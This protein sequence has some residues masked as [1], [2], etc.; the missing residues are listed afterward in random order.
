MVDAVSFLGRFIGGIFS[1]F[2]P[3]ESLKFAYTV[4]SIINSSILAI[5]FILMYE[6]E[7]SLV[8]PILLISMLISGVMRSLSMVPIILL[9]NN[10]N[11]QEDKISLSVW[12]ALFLLGDVV[13]LLLVNWL[14]DLGIQENYA[15]LIFVG[16]NLLVSLLQY[17][18]VDERHTLQNQNGLEYI[19]QTFRNCKAFFSLPRN[20]LWF[21]ETCSLMISYSNIIMWAPYYFS[22]IGFESQTTLISIMYPLLNC[23]SAIIF[24]FGFDQCL[25]RVPIIIIFCFMMNIVLWILL[26]F[27]GHD[28]GELVFQIFCFG[29]IG[30]FFA[31][32]RSWINGYENAAF[33]EG[34][35][36][37]RRQVILLSNNVK[38]IGN[39]ISLLVIGFLV[40]HSNCLHM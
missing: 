7:T 13:S 4:Q 31:A 29:G 5:A 30:F 38:Q 40:E 28:K 36:T 1:I 11:P 15:F 32:G 12:N 22:K 35:P 3:F 24:S 6:V 34:N 2:F 10:S 25:G 19:Q 39:F 14:M 8:K 16:L 9:F 23:V 26:L 20:L 21:I 18:S 17:F 27:I 33:T 37:L